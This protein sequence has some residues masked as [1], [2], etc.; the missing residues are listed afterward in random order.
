MKRLSDET[1]EPWEIADVHEVG[2]VCARKDSED[3][4]TVRIRSHDC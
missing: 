4:K 3:V 2:I 1:G